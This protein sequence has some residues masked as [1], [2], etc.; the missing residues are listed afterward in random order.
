MR[1]LDS[2][3][4]PSPSKQPSAPPTDLGIGA[5]RSGGQIGRETDRKKVFPLS[6]G[7]AVDNSGKCHLAAIAAG[8]E[9]NGPADPA[10]PLRNVASGVPIMDGSIEGERDKLHGEV[11]HSRQPTAT[12]S[13]PNDPPPLTVNLSQ[14]LAPEATEHHLMVAPSA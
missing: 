6:T 12:P 2:G 14:D 13:P 3:F 7:T 11:N 4:T 1:A 9:P 5:S 10:E 8:D